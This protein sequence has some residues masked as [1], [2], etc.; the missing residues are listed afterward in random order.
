MD[1][2]DAWLQAGG[3]DYAEIQANCPVDRNCSW[4]QIWET[5][6]AHVTVGDLITAVQAHIAEAHP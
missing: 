3:P 5:D 4:Y 6:T 1:A 2:K